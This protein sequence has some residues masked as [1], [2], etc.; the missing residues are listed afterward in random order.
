MVHAIVDAEAGPFPNQSRRYLRLYDHKAFPYRRVRP[1]RRAS[2]TPAVVFDHFTGGRNEFQF[3]ADILL[4]DQ[5]HLCAADRAD[6]VFFWKR[7]HYF[8]TFR[9][10]K[11][12]SWVAFF[13]RD[14]P[15]SRSL[16]PAK[17]NLVPFP[18]HRRDSVVPECHRIFFHWM[19]PKSFLV[20]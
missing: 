20:R 5:D 9:P 14:V 1:C 12:S 11:S 16:L 3:T 15:G 13:L 2:V 6:L 4:A 17:R 8:F 18:L 10:L 19:R 7:D